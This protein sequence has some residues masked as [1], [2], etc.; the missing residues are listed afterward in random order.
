MIGPGVSWTGTSGTTTGLSLSKPLDAGF[1]LCHRCCQP[2]LPIDTQR[3]DTHLE[4]VVKGGATEGTG[5]TTRPPEGASPTT[6]T[7]G[8]PAPTGVWGLVIGS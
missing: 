3:A 1:T 4:A 2:I 6:V 5:L 7:A 8:G